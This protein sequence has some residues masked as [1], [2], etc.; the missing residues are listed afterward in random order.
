MAAPNRNLGPCVVIWDP[1]GP[2]RPAG[3]AANVT[4]DKTNG[5]VFF[6]YE[7]LQTPIKRDQAGLTDV[8]DVTTGAVNPEVE[9][10]LSEEEVATLKTVF[11]NSE[12]GANFLKIKNPVGTDIFP[13]SRQL[14]VKPIV[15]GV[16]STTEAEWLYIHRTFPRVTMEQA[17]DN[18]G[19]RGI[20][21]IFKG[22]PDDHSGRQTEMWRYGPKS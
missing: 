9:L 12:V 16:I 8:S 6:R 18:A 2:G 3:I 15:N 5:G 4:F 21:T 17:Y 1:V 20:K 10:P 11:A 22:Y 13:I 14:I 7:E 19:Q